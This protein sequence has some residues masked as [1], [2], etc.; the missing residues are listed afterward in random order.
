MAQVVLMLSMVPIALYF[1]FM[2]FRDLKEVIASKSGGEVEEEEIPWFEDEA[3]AS[4]EASVFEEE[5]GKK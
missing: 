4:G 1:V 2:T 3:E 5:S